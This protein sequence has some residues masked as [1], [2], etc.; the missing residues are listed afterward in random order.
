MRE[1]AEIVKELR[2][3]E[4]TGTFTNTYNYKYKNSANESLEENI[5]LEN[6]C[7]FDGSFKFKKINGDL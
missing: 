2:E 4:K 5:Q 6:N 3:L 1:E 7:S